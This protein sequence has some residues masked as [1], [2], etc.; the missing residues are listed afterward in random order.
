MNDDGDHPHHSSIVIQSSQQVWFTADLLN[1]S[2]SVWF[3]G[4]RFQA[5]LALSVRPAKLDTGKFGDE[6][7]DQTGG[8]IESCTRA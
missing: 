5:S 1:S 7:G 8:L 3:G 6:T 2:E 4:L